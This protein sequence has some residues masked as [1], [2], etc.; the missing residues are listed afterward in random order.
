MISGSV[1]DKINVTYEGSNLALGSG[2]TEADSMYLVNTNIT[3]GG[4]L[5]AGTLGTLNIT[6]ATINVGNG[7]FNSDPDNVYLYANDLIQINNLDFSNSRLD[8]V[9]MEAITVNLNNVDFPAASQV[10][11]RSKDGSLK[12]GTYS[13]PVVGAVNLTNVTHGAINGGKVL[14]ETDFTK[15]SVGYKSSTSLATGHNAFTISSQSRGD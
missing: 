7:G 9:Y 3:T 2:G 8:D 1:S 11:L 5:A 14:A 13:K 15:T 6:N 4:N 12:F 10:H